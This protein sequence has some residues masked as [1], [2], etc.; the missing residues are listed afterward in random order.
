[1]KRCIIIPDSFKGTVSSIQACKI[2]QAA[3][4][5]IFPDC[6]TYMV[7]VADGGEGTVDSF[8]YAMKGFRIEVQTTG[9][10]NEPVVAAYARFGDTAVIET[11]SC[12]GLPLAEGRLNPRVTTTFGM[13]AL[14]QHAVMHGCRK[15]IIGLG[16]SCT[17]DGGTG[18]ARAL[19]TRFYDKNGKEFAPHSD[20]FT[21]I[22]R[23]DTSVTNAYLK[24]IQ[25]TAMCD[26]D[27]PL[28]GPVGAAHM[29]SPQKGADYDTAILLDENLHALAS[30]IAEDLHGSVADVPGAGA[31]GGLGAGILAFFGGELK[32]GIETVLDTVH[33]D[34]MLPGTDMIFTGEG[35][36]DAQSFHGKVI[37]GI[38]NRAKKAGVPVTV[39]AGDIADDIRDDVYD[40]GIIALFS[41]NRKAL[42]FNDIRQ[43]SETYMKKTV[44]D[45]LRLIKTAEKR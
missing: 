8:L 45:I 42:A 41:I 30:R 12:A 34:E 5:S 37:N 21:Q 44:M 40:R 10:Y 31:A 4:I 28:C 24:G 29:F 22:S 1:M 26:I 25:I 33:F 39:I 3:V 35:R 32:S 14:V 13:G 9:P 16:G 11:A 2:I 6:K 23:I 43:Y 15:I 38:A 7:P 17:N 18:F 36:I 27:N 19:G 20:E